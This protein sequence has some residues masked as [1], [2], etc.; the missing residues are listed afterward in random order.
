MQDHVDDLGDTIEAAQADVRKRQSRAKRRM[1]NAAANMRV[2]KS[3]ADK[4]R[5]DYKAGGSSHRH[6]TPTLKLTLDEAEARYKQAEADL[7]FKKAS[8]EC[9]NQDSGA[10]PLRHTRHRDRH[11]KDVKA[12]TIF[13][14]MD[15]LVVMSQIWRG[16][17]MGQVQAGR[18]RFSGSRVH[19]DRE[20][21][22][23]AGR[24]LGQP[25]GEQRISGRSES[26]DQV[27]RI[28]GLWNSAA[29]F[30]TSA[31]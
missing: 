17:E 23:D 9:R 27:R 16:N 3:E 20:H 18:S 5:L 2:T 28:P 4:A 30:T 7:E 10:D 21:R 11:V 12:F 6:R 15:G 29:K 13:A 8:H 31:R 25:G 19:E 14:A 1:G 24:R 26:Q 22:S